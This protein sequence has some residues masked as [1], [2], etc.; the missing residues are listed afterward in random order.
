MGIPWVSNPESIKANQ[1]SVLAIAE[2][3]AAMAVS[4]WIAVR[5]Q[6]YVHI[7]IGASIAPMLLMRT[8]ASCILGE[9]IARNLTT[10]LGSRLGRPEL[11]RA[12]FLSKI[13]WTVFYLVMLPWLA[14]SITLARTAAWAA[15]LVWHPLIAIAA[16]PRNWRHATVVLDSAKSPDVLPAPRQ[17]PENGK[18]E[19][20]W[21]AV[22]DFFRI[23]FRSI[24]PS[25][26]W[27]LILALIIFS[28]MII[29]PAFAYRWSLKSTAII[30][31][32]LL[33]AMHSVRGAG[34]PLRTYLPIYLLDPFS[35]IVLCVSIVAITGFAA[36]IVLWNAWTGFVD[37]WNTTPVLRTLSL[38]VSPGEIQWWQVSMAINAM[39]AIVMYLLAWR[40]LLRLKH[41]ELTDET[42]PRRVFQVGLFIRS[43]LSAYTIASMLYI[44]IRAAFDWNLPPLGSKLFPWM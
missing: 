13:H 37:W 38:Y 33:W 15:A 7:A 16:I 44:T 34:K 12:G 41:R 10:K 8:D 5:W 9:A 30:W 29:L 28:P 1:L 26:E 4:V 19:A 40:W 25:S 3:L 23:A 11:R 35:L 42:M 21:F 43:I 39:I 31:F 22:G 2:T 17:I 27:G 14:T 32:P 6:T 20:S 36:K 24:N 18:P